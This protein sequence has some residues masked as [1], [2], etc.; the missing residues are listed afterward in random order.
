MGPN[1][2]SL[3]GVRRLV[4]TLSPSYKAAADQPIHGSYPS[5]RASCHWDVITDAGLYDIYASFTKSDGGCL[6]LVTQVPVVL[7]CFIKSGIDVICT[8]SP[9]LGLSCVFPYWTWRK[10]FWSQDSSL[11]KAKLTLRPAAD[12]LLL[13]RILNSDDVRIEYYGY[14]DVA[15]ALFIAQQTQISKAIL[16][17][18]RVIFD[19]SSHIIGIGEFSPNLGG[20]DDV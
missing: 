4:R 13:R 19:F 9:A 8:T 17:D 15:G 10:L 12:R 2:K 7:Q 11:L 6:C 16:A 3:K 5:L 20:G 1:L 14:D 18:G